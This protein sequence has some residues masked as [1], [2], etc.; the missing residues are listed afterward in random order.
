MLHAMRCCYIH[1]YMLLPHIHEK[2]IKTY[3]IYIHDIHAIMFHPVLLLFRI[4]E[5]LLREQPAPVSCSLFLPVLLHL[6]ARNERRRYYYGYIRRDRAA[7]IT[8]AAA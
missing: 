8:A 1:T 4:L 5:M 3:I 6:G 7:Y 2:S